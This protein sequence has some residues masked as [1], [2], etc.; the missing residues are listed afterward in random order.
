MISLELATKL[1]EAG[2]KWKPQVGDCYYRVG[3]RYLRMVDY[4]Q[5]LWENV[6]PGYYVWG[7]DVFVPRLDQ[8]LG[9]IE[10]LG[11]RWNLNCFGIIKIHDKDWQGEVYHRKEFINDSSDD[12]SAEALIWILE[13]GK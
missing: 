12:A 2:M 4:D 10:G 9:T 3:A 1:K 6:Q 7:T 8:L 11:W 5:L 13:G